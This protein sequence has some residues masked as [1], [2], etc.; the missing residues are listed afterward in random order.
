[1]AGTVRQ[2]IDQ[3]ALERY[4]QKHLPE[5]K[6]PLELKQFGFGQ[7]NPTYQASDSTGKKYVIRKK[8]PGKLLS[9]TAHQVEREYRVLHAL[10][11][12]DVAVPKTYILCEDD[13]IIGT[14]F[15]IIEHLDGRMF[16]NPALVGVSPSD[17]KEMWR[18]A[19]KTLAKLHSVDIKKV[20]L[21]SLGKN[22]GFY[23]R[24]VKTFGRLAQSQADARDKDSNEP[25]LK[26][27]QRNQPRDRNVLGHGDYKIDNLV[28]HTTESRVIGIL[29]CETSTLAHP[30]ADLTN[31]I[32]P[33]TISDATPSWPRI[34]ADKAFLDPS[35]PDSKASEYPGLPTK[36]EALQW[37]EE[38]VGW[39]I[40]SSELTWATAF[41][42]FR[43]SIIFQGIA[44]R[45][46]LRQASNEKAMVYAQERTPFAEMAWAMVGKAVEESG[47]KAR[48]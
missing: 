43:D 40:P 6:S 28:F 12:T 24:Q 18:Q 20:G 8:P 10:E 15:Y 39:Q 17:R 26:F 13:S 7:S 48:L 31:L 29:D 4:I 11:H 41:A 34:H 30:Y 16:E 36:Q 22:G 35:Q 47:G 27:F 45:H 3:A 9:K 1:M 21:E 46:A 32:S 14:A 42:L 25:F 2:P 44:A 19:V 37:Y 38:T 33:W 23:N 5:I